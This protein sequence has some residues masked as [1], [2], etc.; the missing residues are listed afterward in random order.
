ME[1]V[2]DGSFL[3]FHGG[4]DF[5]SDLLFWAWPMALAMPTVIFLDIFWPSDSRITPSI[6]AAN[7][8]L[9]YGDE[10]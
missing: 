6:L 10:S 2:V 3:K 5:V 4:D 1:M 8:L 7:G 9:P